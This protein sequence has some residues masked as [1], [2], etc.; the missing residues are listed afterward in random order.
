MPATVLTQANGRAKEQFT[1]SVPVGTRQRLEE[2]RKQNGLKS[3]NQ[4]VYELLSRGFIESDSLIFL[5]AQGDSA[6]AA[7]PRAESLASHMPQPRN[8]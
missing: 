4:A 3:R 1:I 8:K 5:K 6:K 7:K 2:F